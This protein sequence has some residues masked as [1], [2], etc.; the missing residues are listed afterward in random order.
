VQIREC[1][2]YGAGF[3]FDLRQSHRRAAPSE[4]PQVDFQMT[5]LRCEDQRFGAAATRYRR[6]SAVTT[7]SWFATTRT[8]DVQVS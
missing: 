4:Y 8:A 2:Q 7:F 3:L 1:R 6:K 5:G